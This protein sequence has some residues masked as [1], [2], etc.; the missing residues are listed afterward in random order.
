MFVYLFSFDLV[1][2]FHH[3][4]NQVQDGICVQGAQRFHQIHD[5]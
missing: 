2:L 1:R 4:L 3:L 5:G